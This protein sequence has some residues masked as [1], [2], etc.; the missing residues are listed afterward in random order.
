MKVFKAVV[1][2]LF[3]MNKSTDF[4]HFIGIDVSKK[5]LDISVFEGKNFLYHTQIE[6]SIGSFKKFVLSLK[7]Q[8]VAIEK[9]LFCAENTGIYNEPIKSITEETGLWLWIEKP[10]QIIKSQGIVR[11]KNDKIDSFRIALY[12]Y[13]NQE[14]AQ[15]WESPRK[16]LITINRLLTL[17]RNLLGNLKQLKLVLC[18]KAFLIQDLD[19]LSTCCQSSID[20]LKRDIKIIEKEILSLIKS[21]SELDHKYQLITSVEGVGM[22]TAIEVIIATNEFKNFD[23]AKK[24]ACYCGVVP[25]EYSSGTSVNKRTRVSSMANKTLKT[26]LHMAAL[27][28]VRMKGELQDYFIR[29][30]SQGKNKMLVINAIRNKL[31]LR[32]F[33]VVK[34]DQA[35]QKD[36]SFSF[37]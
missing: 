35:Y 8:K 2:N 28:V 26:L 11:G 33:A 29:K 16:V 12:A 31:I 34:K 18:E 20:A 5:T 9:C 10:L 32:I 3:L 30:V 24:F 21:D 1:L 23:N 37:G 7:K 6:N 15:K 17:R 4:S 19:L 22:F 25:F 27:S 14:E 13:K 36:F